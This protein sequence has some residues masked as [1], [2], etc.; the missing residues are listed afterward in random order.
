MGTSAV[1]F[2][3]DSASNSFINSQPYSFGAPYPSAEFTTFFTEPS[4]WALQAITVPTDPVRIVE[5]LPTFL[6]S[7]RW[8]GNRQGGM[9]I[10]PP[11]EGKQTTTDYH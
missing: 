8:R 5:Q 11:A 7:F 6:R 1:Y 2:I 3:Y 4:K 9:R 10:R